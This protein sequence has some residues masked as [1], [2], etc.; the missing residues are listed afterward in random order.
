MQTAEISDAAFQYLKEQAE[1]LVD[2]TASVL[3]R[4]IAEHK[5][6]TASKNVSATIAEISFG[7]ADLPSVTHSTIIA[8]RVNGEAVPKSDW[9]HSLSHLMSVIIQSGV[10]SELVRRS[11]AANFLQGPISDA[12]E[13]KGYRYKAGGDDWFFQGLDA[14]RAC[15]NLAKLSAKFNVTLE[16]RI[17]W[18][19]SA[20]HGLGGKTAVLKLP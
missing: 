17:Q 2:T 16:I 15:K 9:N 18:G 19:P 7:A 12:D 4:I 11:V 13:K 1:P 20:K 6:M 5:K 14:E 10:K 3:D 8:S